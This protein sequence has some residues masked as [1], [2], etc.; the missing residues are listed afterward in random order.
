MCNF[1]FYVLILSN[2][3]WFVKLSRFIERTKIGLLVPSSFLYI[4]TMDTLKETSAFKSFGGTT[5]CFSHTSTKTK[6]PMAFSVFFPKEAEEVGKVPVVFY[7]SGLTCTDQNA[8]TKGGFQRAAASHGLAMVFP[9]TS[10][11]GANVPGESE[12]WDFG[13]GAG[14]YV[15]ATTPNWKE[16]YNMYGYIVEELPALLGAKFGR[17]LDLNRASIMGHS[18]GGHGALIAALKN[19]G[20]FQSCSAFSPICNPMNCPWGKKA[21]TGYL[22]EDERSW[23]AWDA[24]HL[25]REYKGNPIQIL[26]DQGTEDKFL[27]DRQ[28][29]PDALVDAAKSSQAISLQMRMQNGY[30][31]SYYFI[32]TFAQDH[33]DFHAA[34][35][36]SAS[37]L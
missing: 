2:Y 16:H 36:K 21:F 1:V 22:G 6:T 9:D 31:H 18:M 26:V 7:L 3:I 17:E 30:D 24:T 27:G 10:P 8:L 20:M 15:T 33:V 37:G 5:R 35:L 29:L 23:A 14:F 19:P 11:R 34:F 4:L 12:S 13:L 28:L 25:A 32:S